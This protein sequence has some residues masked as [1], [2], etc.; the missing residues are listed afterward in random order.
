[1]RIKTVFP[2]ETINMFYFPNYLTR[3]SKDI[4]ASAK[5]DVTQLLKYNNLCYEDQKRNN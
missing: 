1:M 3:R 5:L 4:H 2:M